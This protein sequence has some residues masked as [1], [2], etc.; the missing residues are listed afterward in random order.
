M[1]VLKPTYKCK[2]IHDIKVDILNKMSVKVVLLDVDNTITS[3][4]SKTP[5]DG[6]VM[7]A[8]NLE[9][10]GFK[11]YIVSNNFE[12]RVSKIAKKFDLPYISFAMKPFPKGFRKARKALGVKAQQ[13]VVVGDQIFTDILGANLGRMKSILVEPVEIET[14]F[15]FKIRRALEKRVRS[16]ALIIE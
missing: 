11:V 10:K 12:E 15:T 9:D 4:I 2:N 6:S 3:Y 5:L 14:G 13:C 16:K 7:W 8:K 1:P